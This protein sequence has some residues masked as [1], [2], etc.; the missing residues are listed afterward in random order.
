MAGH[1]KWSQ[2]K[3]KKGALDQKRGA[4]FSKLSRAITV[5]AKQGVADPAH[6][7]ALAQAVQT[8]K[9]NRMPKDN[10]ERAIAKASGAGASE[11]WETILYEGY[12]PG[13]AAVIVDC[14]TDN[15]NRTAAEVRHA[16]SRAGGSL[17]TSGCVAWMFERVGEIELAEGTD[18]E[19][20]ILAA[21]DAGADD[22][23]AE[24][25]GP[26]IVSCEAPMLMA[27]RSA[28]EEA[29][30]EVVRSEL[31]MRPSN[32]IELDASQAGSMLRLIDA[33]EDLDDVQATWSN[34]DVS[35][36]VLEA[37]AEG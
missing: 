3:R 25:G 23:S 12:G 37:V 6:N 20:A 2:I 16:F 9:D 36:Q 15:R 8:A 35:E 21:A 29:G 24:D 5:A 11:A 18:E 32:T 7:A 34:F 22:A 31:T 4:L 27:V 33:L 17:G 14:L 13:G 1:S 30:L 26:V 28:L 19:E 10:I